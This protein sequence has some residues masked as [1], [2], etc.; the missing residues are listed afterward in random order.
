[1]L[2]TG[3]S[4]KA[5]EKLFGDSVSLSIPAKAEY[6]SVARM[7]TAAA[8]SRWGLDVEGIEDIKVA[9]AEACANFINYSCDDG[10]NLLNI[11]CT[12]RQD[13]IWIDVAG[14]GKNMDFE[15]TTGHDFAPFDDEEGLGTFIIKSLMDKVEFNYVEDRCVSITMFKFFGTD[16]G[17]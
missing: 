4:E 10:Q 13:G 11:V 1:M 3:D 14:C 12:C 16:G 2:K 15:N 17:E 7:C 5:R 9:V 8:V 6:V